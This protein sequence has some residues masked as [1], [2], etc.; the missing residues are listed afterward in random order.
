MEDLAVGAKTN[1]AGPVESTCDPNC[2]GF[3]DV[4]EP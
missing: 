2:S 3:E 4:Y 1:E